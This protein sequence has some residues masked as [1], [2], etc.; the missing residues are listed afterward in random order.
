VIHF[1]LTTKVFPIETIQYPN[2][3]KATAWHLRPPVGGSCVGFSGTNDQHRLLPS[4]VHQHPLIGSALEATNGRMLAR[5]LEC[6]SYKPLPADPTQ[7]PWEALL[8]FA[9][10]TGASALIDAGALLAGVELSNAAA[11]LLELLRSTENSLKLRA[12]VYF[13]RTHGVGGEW[14]LRDD[15]GHTWTLKQAPIAERDAFVVFDE[16]HCRGSDM[17]LKPS[18]L[19]VLTL[20]P[21]MA[22]DKL[23]QAAGRLRRLGANQKLILAAQFDVHEQIITLRD[24]AASQQVSVPTVLQWVM[25]NTVAASR[26]GL[27]EWAL[28]GMH[29]CSTHADRG[30]ALL[31]EKLEVA[32][33]YGHATAADDLGQMITKATQER[34]SVEW[35]SRDEH[36]EYVKY[37]KMIESHAYNYGLGTQILASS[38]DEE[39]E[40]ELEQEQ[41]KLKE[42]EKEIVE[43]K[44]RREVDWNVCPEVLRNKEKFFGAA[45]VVSLTHAV[46]EHVRPDTLREIEWRLGA[47]LDLVYMT[48]NFLRTAQSNDL[49]MHLRTVDAFVFLHGFVVL[50][51]DRETDALLDAEWAAAEDALAARS[52]LW[53]TVSSDLLHLSY[54]ARLDSDRKG[55]VLMDHRLCDLETPVP[56]E[57]V[58]LVQLFNGNTMFPRPAAADA[59]KKALHNQQAR[60]VARTFSSNRGLDKFFAG[61]HLARFC[62]AD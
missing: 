44:E 23:M 36:A 41:E 48:S 17:R 6:A 46:T 24:D 22:K 43:M 12:V 15:Q 53:E 28:N 25:Q 27:H 56:S 61:S 8:K 19:A 39:C 49:S 51:S 5:L 50:L 29:L 7:A 35:R 14:M 16:R 1:W 47:K 2:R 38:L 20:G 18:A 40:R 60:D 13:E 58:G 31:R 30:A 42:K 45:D 9:V 34:F 55:R 62:E 37:V 21:R 10:S 52:R 57:A 32:E 59:V 3:L 26:Q 33:F 54:T 11:T 4:H